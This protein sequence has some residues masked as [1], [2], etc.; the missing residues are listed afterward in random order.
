MSMSPLRSQTSFWVSPVHKSID[1]RDSAVNLWKEFVKFGKKRNAN[2][3]QTVSTWQSGSNLIWLD[4]FSI[5]L[6]C[7]DSSRS[8]PNQIR[9]FLSPRA[10]SK[11]RCTNA[12]WEITSGVVAEVRF[13]RMQLKISSSVAGHY[14]PE[15]GG[16]ARFTE[17]S[18]AKPQ[19]CWSCRATWRCELKNAGALR[20]QLVS[21]VMS[22][23][24]SVWT[25]THKVILRLPSMQIRDGYI[26][27]W[28]LKNFSSAQTWRPQWYIMNHAAANLLPTKYNRYEYICI[29]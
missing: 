25:V 17:L 26:A 20:Y 27:K 10:I 11:T 8:H 4:K 9:N 14:L 21:R 29:V 5:W 24:L 15:D 22:A 3:G 7:L 2:A 18:Y 1:I 13:K 12:P 16:S 6:D 19:R 23:K 28:F